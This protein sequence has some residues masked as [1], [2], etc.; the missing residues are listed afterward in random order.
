[1]DESDWRNKLSQSETLEEFEALEPYIEN[2]EVEEDLRYI[3]SPEILRAF[4]VKYAIDPIDAL[5]ITFNNYRIDFFEVFFSFFT[6][7]EVLE[8]D[9]VLFSFMVHT[10]IEEGVVDVGADAGDHLRRDTSFSLETGWIVWYK[11]RFKY[12]DG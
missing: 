4:I 12:K 3:N 1:M 10:M 11:R 5:C 9:A 6:L 2:V 7:E 8:R